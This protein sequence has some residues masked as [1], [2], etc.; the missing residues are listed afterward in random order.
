MLTE[1]FINLCC[2]VLLDE[3]PRFSTTLIKDIDSIFEFYSDDDTP[4]A[5][6]S[7]H[8]LVKTIIKLKNDKLPTDQIIDSL[9]VTGYFKEFSNFLS[10][11]SKQK[12]A[13]EKID[14]AINQI[15]QR[16]QYVSLLVDMPKIESYIKQFNTQSFTD[17][18]PALN[19]WT[20]LICNVHSRILEERRKESTTTIKELDLVN[21][22][23]NP[24]LTSIENSYGGRNSVST[25]YTQLDNFMNGGFEP[26]RLYIFGGSSGDGK[27]TL[28]LNFI[29]HAVEK[30]KYLDGPPSII[31]Y[32][33]LEN[34]VDESLIRLY[35]CITNQSTSELIKKFSTEKLLIEEYLKEWQQKYNCIVIMKYFQ[36]TLTSVAELYSSNELIKAKYNGSAVIRSTYVDYLDLLKS[37]QT[38]DVHRLEIGQVT[39]DMK[40]SSVLQGVP[41]VTVTQLNRGGYDTKEM[42]TLVNMSESIKK[43]EHSDFVG[44]IKSTSN[45][46][47]KNVD[48]KNKPLFTT[49]IGDMAITI[50]KNRSGPKNKM[51]TL[52]VDFSKFRVDD[53]NRDDHILFSPGPI[54]PGACF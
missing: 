43:V 28:L 12:I 24:V 26:G 6:R 53:K 49:G 54:M 16:K 5:F 13:P 36:P 7:K 2:A 22:N 42:P 18:K 38:F 23:Y 17:L 9:S 10:V 41:W 19:G 21:D 20:D 45:E 50:G 32:Y 31:P 44:I 48:Q 34:L 47:D 39:L 11:L 27:S 8:K 33:T 51:I 25:G 4:L 46:V 40:V 52:S 29:R 3:N 15:I 35:C 37:G 14:A 1:S 30:N